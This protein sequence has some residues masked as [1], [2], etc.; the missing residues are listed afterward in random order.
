MYDALF[1]PIRY[2]GRCARNR[3]V[4]APMVTNFADKDGTIT[5]RLVDYYAERARGE[6]GTIVVEAASIGETVRIANYQIGAFS[7]RFIPGLSRLA[8]AIRDAGAVALVQLCHGGPKILTAGGLKTVSVSAVG[9]RTGDVPHALSIEG[10][11]RVRRDFVAAARRAQAA[12]F[13]G[14]EIHAAHFYLLSAAISPFTNH[15]SD[16]YGGGIENRTRLPREVA[17]DVKAAMGDG[18]SVWVRINAC[19]K[20]EEGLSLEDGVRAAA[21]LSGSGADVIHVSAYATP[22]AKH[23]KSV[24]RIPVGGGPQ[25]DSPPGAY[26][27]YAGAVK[28][29]VP[30]PVVAVGKLDDP[31]IS[32]KAISDKMCDMIAL[33]RQLLC[34]PYWVLKLQEGREGD[35][36]HCDYCAVCHHALTQGKEI[37]CAR[38]SNLFGKP[39]YPRS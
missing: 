39:S 15:R 11:R 35:I 38:N 18:F 32:N 4:M 1:D 8:G 33:G 19:E 28:K 17:S 36:F 6:V 9:V 12:G 24:L 14:V 30:V 16:R 13:D 37:I 7:D 25:K 27:P 23:A 5:D 29:A 21:I 26:L 22:V 3:V 34:D 2:S 31:A 10:L 20:M